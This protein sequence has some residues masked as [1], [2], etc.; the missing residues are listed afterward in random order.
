MADKA[1]SLGCRSID[2]LFLTESG[3]SSASGLP[4]LKKRIKIEKVYG[5]YGPLGKESA[6]LL[7]DAKAL[8]PGES[9][10]GKDWSASLEWPFSL[11]KKLRLSRIKGYSGSG[12]EFYSWRFRTPEA[13]L[14]TCAPLRC[15]RVR[16]VGKE[17]DII[18]RRG[19]A[20][21]FTFSAAELIRNGY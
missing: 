16:A 2:A 17:F 20:A 13:E 7:A 5:P 15:A 12:E 4:A 11:D 21:E 3:A 6:E 18:F 19:A 1:L 14:Q 8:W 10:S 9:I